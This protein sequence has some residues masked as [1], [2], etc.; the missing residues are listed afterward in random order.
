MY[1]VGLDLSRNQMNKL[2]KGAKAR[3]KKGMGCNLIVRPETYNILTR[4]FRRNKG[5]DIMLSPEEI[6]LNTVPSPEQQSA[7]MEQTNQEMASSEA[8]GMGLLKKLKKLEKPAIKASKAIAKKYGPDIAKQVSK[9]GFKYA[10]YDDKDS[11]K[12]SNVVKNITKTGLQAGLGK[13]LGAGLY[14]GRGFEGLH[15][16]HKSGLVADMKTAQHISDGIK[17]L[18]QPRVM[19]NGLNLVEGKGVLMSSLHQAQQPQ[20]FSANYHFKF[21]LPPQ[22]QGI[23]DMT[24][25][26]LYL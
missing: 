12:Y 14:A 18:R 8:V 17:K 4:A 23:Q 24:G 26:G 1:T 9:E 20:P 22:Y 13:G 3:V 5:A 19:G 6:E 2:R 11:D 7:L 10:G 25:E 15:K 21:M 16:S